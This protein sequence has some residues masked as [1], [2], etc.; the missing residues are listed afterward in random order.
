[1]SSG[2]PNAAAVSDVSDVS[3]DVLLFGLPPSWL[4]VVGVHF[5]PNRQKKT[6]CNF[7]EISKL[8]EVIVL[9]DKMPKSKKYDWHFKVAF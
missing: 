3:D 7:G 5:D 6:Y 2:V 8:A 1:V 9:G 4:I